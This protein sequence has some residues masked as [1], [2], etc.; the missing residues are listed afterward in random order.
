MKI[1]DVIYVKQGTE[2]VGRG[3]ITSPYKY[4]PSILKGSK[5]VDWHHYVK[6]DWE[7]NFKQVKICLGAELVTVLR[8]DG[9]RLQKLKT[10]IA[11]ANQKYIDDIDAQDIESQ[12]LEESDFKEGEPKQRYINYYERNPR[13]RKAAKRIH[14]LRCKVCDFDFKEFYGERGVEYIEVHHLRPVSS[15]DEEAL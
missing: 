6:V 3:K 1:G 13:L 10:A 9:D 4:D 2:I 7:K 11:A 15:R 5:V 8:L 14:G 12:N